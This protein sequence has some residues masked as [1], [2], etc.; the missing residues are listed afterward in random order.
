MY[1]LHRYHIRESHSI[2]CGLRHGSIK[3]IA[4]CVHASLH[5][6]TIHYGFPYMEAQNQISVKNSDSCPFPNVMQERFCKLF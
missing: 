1:N 3:L 6:F 5:S 2:M 4:N